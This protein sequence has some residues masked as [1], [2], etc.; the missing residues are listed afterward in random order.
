MRPRGHL[1]STR[2]IPAILNHLVCGALL[3]E[4]LAVMQG[5]RT[6][7]PSHTSPSPAPGNAF[8]TPSCL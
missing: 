8:A 5:A 4:P 3:Q 1:D 7:G 6:T 2:V